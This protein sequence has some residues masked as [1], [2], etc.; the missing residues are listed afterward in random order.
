MEPY[1]VMLSESQERMIISVNPNHEDIVIKICEKWGI[2]FAKIGQATNDG[3][4]QIAYNSNPVARIPTTL[5]TNPPNY[6]FN[7]TKP[8]YIKELESFDFDSIKLSSNPTDSLK[9][10]LSSPNIVSKKDIYQQYDHQVQ[11]NTIIPPG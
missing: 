2:S 6:K 4:A 8:S 9:K 5:L 11:T 10:L 3:I 7:V 1:E